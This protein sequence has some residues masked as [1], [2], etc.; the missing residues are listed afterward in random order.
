MADKYFQFKVRG[1]GLFPL[2]MLRYDTCWPSTSEDVIKLTARHKE[3]RTV[4]MCGISLLSKR[5]T[6]DLIKKGRFPTAERWASFGWEVTEVRFDSKTHF[7][8]FEVLT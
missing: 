3:P 6:E 5:D 2:D 7:F 8:K 4:E 1:E